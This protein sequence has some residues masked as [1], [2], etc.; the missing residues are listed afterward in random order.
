MKE[1]KNKGYR[2]VLSSHY[3]PET[4]KDVDTKID[5]LENLTE[6]AKESENAEAFEKKVKDIYSE[7]SG[8]NYLDMTAGFF[9]PNK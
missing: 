5:Y 7:Y 9:F 6:L 4:L 8:L 1:Y 2:L 3:V